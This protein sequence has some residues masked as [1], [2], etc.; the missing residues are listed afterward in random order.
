MSCGV[1]DDRSTDI[2]LC[3]VRCLLS[4]STARSSRTSAAVGRVDNSVVLVAALTASANAVRSCG[5]NSSL[6]SRAA[7]ATLRNAESSSSRTRASNSSCDGLASGQA[8]GVLSTGVLIGFNNDTQMMKADRLTSCLVCRLFVLSCYHCE[9]LTE[10]RVERAVLLH[11]R[12]R[13][14]LPPY[15]PCRLLVGERVLDVH[16]THYQPL[17]ADDRMPDILTGRNSRLQAAKR[18]THTAD[19]LTN[20]STVTRQWRADTSVTYLEAELD[21]VESLTI[22]GQ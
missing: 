1:T 8:D 19:Q 20:R 14:P 15:R 11:L 2:P 3:S 16:L 21:V 12:R 17:T 13:P 22:I 7:V 18:N 4:R 9:L 6:T 5:S 10:Q